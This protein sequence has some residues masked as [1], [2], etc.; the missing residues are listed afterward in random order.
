MR[1]ENHKKKMRDGTKFS[2]PTIVVNL[3][4]PR[5]SHQR[6]MA[7]YAIANV[8]VCVLCA[9]RQP[10]Q[11]QQFRIEESEL[12][13]KITLKLFLSNLGLSFFFPFRPPNALR[14]RPVPLK[15]NWSALM[16][17]LV[18]FSTF[19]RINIEH[20]HWQR[21]N[22]M[23]KKKTNSR[24]PNAYQRLLGNLSR[25]HRASN[26]SLFFAGNLQQLNASRAL[27]H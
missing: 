15:L 20:C 16:R 22:W 18:F 7:A 8:C 6:G 10:G 13:M 27:S 21:K 9:C 12:K 1:T 19:F 3:K 24:L 26:I 2:A 25:F 11:H 14:C 23:A 4:S 5:S 17:K